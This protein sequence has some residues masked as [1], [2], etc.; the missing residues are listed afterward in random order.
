V[1]FPVCLTRLL[2]HTGIAR[3]LPR[4]QQLA[5]GGSAF[6]D[7]YSDRLLAGLQTPLPELL[8]L[9]QSSAGDLIDLA[10]CVPCFDVV[11]SGS[12]KLP[13]DRRG[14]P[15]P[16]GLPELLQIVA[17]KLHADHELD[18]EVPGEVLITPGVS[19][20]FGLV[21]DALLNPGGRVVLFDP[22][23]PLYRL[24]IAQR[25]GRVRWVPTWIEDGFIRYDPR[26][27]IDRLRHSRLIVLNAPANPTGGLFR[28]EDLEQIAWWAHRFDAI[29]FSDEVSRDGCHDDRPAG[30]AAL[31]RARE[32]TLI[33]GS[34][35]KSHAL[36]A[37]RVGWL[38]GH[39][40]LLRP[41]LLTSVL[42]ALAVPTLSQQVALT[43]LQV[44]AEVLQPVRADFDARRRY[45]FER[46]RNMGLRPEWPAGGH[47]HWIPV[48]ELGLN[49][50]QFAEKLAAARK[51]LVWPGHHFGPGGENHIR[52]S[53]AGDD[54]R[55]RQGLKRLADFVG[56]LQATGPAEVRKRAA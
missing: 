23:A 9:R 38:A 19:G 46:L 41:C 53:Y 44:G 35:S 48:G 20:A 13:A 12:A 50:Q 17:E 51:V 25:R 21:L 49:G 28:P 18:F 36:T 14:M 33:A 56:Q 29:I 4:Y 8:A 11:P 43:A 55:L 5:D 39:R 24:A 22:A 16:A 26:R 42:Q 47:C 6:L 34:V 2:I 31:P 54:G 30:I 37:A 40:H 52:I 7:C 45:T 3:F 10:T 15:P 32:R 1:A 27:L